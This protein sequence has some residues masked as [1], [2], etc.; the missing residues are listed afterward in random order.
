MIPSEASA[1]G[2]ER[3][4]VAAAVRLSDATLVT[5]SARMPVPTYER[6]A[7]TAAIVHLGVGGFHRA[8]QAMYVERL[9]NAGV[10]PKWRICGVG[11]LASDRPTRQALAAQDHLYTLVQKHGNGRYEPRVIGAIADYLYGP[12]DPEAV[13]RRLADVSTQLVSLT[14]TEGGYAIDDV[15]GQFNPRAPGIADDLEPGAT[16][17]TAIGLLVAAL[18]RRRRAGREPFTVMSCDNLPGNGSLTRESLVSFAGR[19]D[20]RLAEWIAHEVRFPNSMVD[21]ITPATTEA[22]REDIRLRLGVDDRWPVV[23]EPFVQWILEESFGLGG[24]PLEEAG[25]QIV[26]S[27]APYET[28]KLRLLNGSHQGLCYFGRLCGFTYIHEA[29]QDPLL[30]EFV[31]VYM[32]AEAVPSL[33]PV[34]GV[35]LSAYRDT[36]IER[37]SNPHIRDTIARVAAYTSDRIPKWVVPVLRHQLEHDGPIGHGAAIIASWARYAEGID[38]QGRPI[39]VID[40][41]R[42]RMMALAARHGADPVAFIS[43]RE[44]FGDLASSERFVE[45]YQAAL[46]SLHERG[47]RRT[48]EA[49]VTRPV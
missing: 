32:D 5:L 8:H 25:V 13:V 24:L 17:R 34:P 1:G 3:S 11:V 2:V 14:I 45:A 41:R 39:E 31:R 19:L 33:D 42:D 49:L 26:P 10:S 9:L 30:S 40:R 36:L 6:R 21:R 7:G 18:A 48:L 27:V 20:R 43:E 15:T 12:E 47:A 4:H 37:F 28:M 38:E 22:D 29:A 16:P 35:D 23:C 44:L 46:R